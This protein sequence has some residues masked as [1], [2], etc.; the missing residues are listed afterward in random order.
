MTT[1]K[2]GQAL[3][4]VAIAN[5]VAASETVEARVGLDQIAAALSTCGC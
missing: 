3:V 2:T 5:D 1:T 4:F